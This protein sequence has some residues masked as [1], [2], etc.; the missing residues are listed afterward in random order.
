MDGGTESETRVR[1]QDRT[2]SGEYCRF[3][4]AEKR[5]VKRR[6]VQNGITKPEADEITAKCTILFAR[7]STY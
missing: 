5:E 1:R 7:L 2:G 6:E 4:S 3:K